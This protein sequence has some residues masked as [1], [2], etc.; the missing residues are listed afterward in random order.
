LV[1]DVIAESM[2]YRLN[3]R[4]GQ[5]LSRD[6]AYRLLEDIWNQDKAGMNRFSVKVDDHDSGSCESS[7]FV[8]SLIGSDNDIALNCVG[9]ILAH[10]QRELMRGEGIN[11][12][13]SD[14]VSTIEMA[15]LLVSSLWL[16]L[17]LL[18]IRVFL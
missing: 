15:S 10:V 9:C 13:L 4:P 11:Y 8:E 3:I 16:A 1:T 14:K 17:F 6:T 7:L 5:E 12:G 2:I 18:I